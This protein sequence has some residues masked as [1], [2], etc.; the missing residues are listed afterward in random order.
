[1]QDCWLFNIY[2]CRLYARQLIGQHLLLQAV[3]K[4]ADWSTFTI[5]G[6]MQDCWLVNSCPL[7]HLCQ[8]IKECVTMVIMFTI[9][10]KLLQNPPNSIFCQERKLS[11]RFCLSSLKRLLCGVRCRIHLFLFFLLPPTPVD[12]Q[13]CQRWFISTFCWLSSV[14]YPVFQWPANV[15]LSISKIWTILPFTSNNAHQ[16]ENLKLEFVSCFF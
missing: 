6:C 13:S 10:N 12:K 8:P 2:Y 9:G 7:H 3:C 16:N 5:V 14:F 1:M 11:L 4:T 15:I